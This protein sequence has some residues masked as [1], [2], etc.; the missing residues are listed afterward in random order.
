MVLF[1][2]VSASAFALLMMQYMQSMFD[3]TRMMYDYNT[4]Y[5]LANAGVELGLA[6]HLDAIID[7]EQLSYAVGYEHTYTDT[8]GQFGCN[9]MSTCGLSGT[10]IARDR[11]HTDSV[12][13]TLT[14]TTDNAF[15]LSDGASLAFPLFL[16]DEEKNIENIN[17]AAT[18]ITIIGV[19]SA[20]APSLDIGATVMIQAGNATN[21]PLYDIATHDLGG[22]SAFVID[23][24]KTDSD[25]P[26]A[27]S[28]KMGE[29]LVF[30][31][32]TDEEASFCISSS[33][34]LA[35][36]RVRVDGQ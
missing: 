16:L 34:P 2:L 5:Y 28:G 26:Q 25:T 14:C 15:V 7:G 22:E 33:T 20:S 32:N 18:K 11:F 31:N 23:A 24:I 27:P 4:A 10:I 3:N 35:S 6:D 1:I 21:P 13:N 9:E 30:I 19:E 12:E 36:Q 29:Y 8:T 17:H